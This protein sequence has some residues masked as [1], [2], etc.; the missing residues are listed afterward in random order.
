MTALSEKA[1]QTIKEETAGSSNM[2]SQAKKRQSK[3]YE[4]MRSCSVADRM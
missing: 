4:L 3:I 1:A 2:K